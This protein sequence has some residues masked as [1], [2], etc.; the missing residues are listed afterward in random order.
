MTGKT[1]LL[2]ENELPVQDIIVTSLQQ[3]KCPTFCAT[4]KESCIQLFSEH[5]PDVVIIDI[6]PADFDRMEFINELIEFSPSTFVIVTATVTHMDKVVEAQK[7]GAYDYIIKPIQVPEIISMTV[8]KCL[9]NLEMKLENNRYKNLAELFPEMI[10]EADNDLKLVFVNQR[11]IELFGYDRNDMKKGLY[12]FD[13]IIDSDRERAS[14]NQMKR[15][16]GEELGLVEY[17]AKRKD[18]STFPIYMH[19]TTIIRKGKPAGFR[20]IIVDLS[21]QKQTEEELLN[22]QLQA[23]ESDMLKATFLSNISHEIRT[24]MNGI[25]GFSNLLRASDGVNEDQ[26]QY[27]EIINQSSKRMLNL[28]NDIV[29][30]SKIETGQ[31]KLDYTYTPLNKVIEEQ[32][33]I[34]LQQAASQNIDL[35]AEASLTNELSTFSFDFDKVSQV[36]NNLINNAIKFT[37]TGSVQFGYRLKDKMVE[38]FVKDTGIGISTT[39]TN[40]IFDRFRQADTSPAR[41]F[42][43]SGLGL[44]ISKALVEM[45]GGKIWVE[46]QKGAGSTFTFSLPYKREKETTFIPTKVVNINYNPIP[47]GT[48]ILVAEDDFVSF[49]LLKNILKR[50]GITAVHAVNGKEAVEKINEYPNIDI[51]LMDLEM[52][53][54]SGIEATTIIKRNHPNKKIIVQTA[55]TQTTNKH[56]AIEAGCDAYI[57][58]PINKKELKHILQEYLVG[59]LEVQNN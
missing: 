58:K 56:K 44:P 39:M 33:H 13:L 31:T 5:Q 17:T 9:Q 23:I 16:Q 40:K 32:Y 26:Q 50:W 14:I 7:R 57:T 15:I 20:G 10:F 41:K 34:H 24:P 21:Q 59:V 22:T 25:I 45:H 52:P 48:T 30:I 36:L 1:I 18:G 29:D 19:I 11:A 47:A 53:E 35:K 27:I 38:I 55:F 12:C 37:H 6:V 3:K 8:E 54:M 49:L 43:G 42:G 4:D 2:F 46:S 28:I 51:I